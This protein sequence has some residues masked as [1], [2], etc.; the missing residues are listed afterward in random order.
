[1]GVPLP[2]GGIGTSLLSA[3]A[4]ASLSDSLLSLLK[5]EFCFR[6]GGSSEGDVSEVQVLQYFRALN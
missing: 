4:L 3:C 6:G 1:M 5:V 2:F